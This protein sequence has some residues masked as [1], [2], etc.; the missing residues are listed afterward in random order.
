MK[1]FTEE[2]AS[3]VT[4][5]SRRQ[6][7]AWDKRGFFEPELAF[8]NRR[9]PYS[10]IY[11]FQDLVGLRAISTLLKKYRVPLRELVKVAYELKKRGYKSWG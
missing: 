11:S 4:G 5:L 3:R 8:D 6:L 1:A 9:S 2:H 10:R 7:R